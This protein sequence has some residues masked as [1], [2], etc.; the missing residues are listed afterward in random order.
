[1]IDEPSDGMKHKSIIKITGSTKLPIKVKRDW[2]K[3]YQNDK[4]KNSN[5]TGDL[6]RP[7]FLYNL[8]GKSSKE[9]TRC[10]SQRLPSLTFH[11]CFSSTTR[12][13][14]P[15]TSVMPKTIRLG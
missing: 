10:K 12:L 1:M 3:D 13:V 5:E 2:Q 14:F 7:H 8:S 15:P 11:T 6:T 9:E 4:P